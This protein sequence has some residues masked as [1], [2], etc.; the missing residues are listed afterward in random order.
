MQVVERE[1]ERLARREHAEQL[2]DRLVRAMTF[3]GQRE[4]ARQLARRREHPCELL[5]R[6][7]V[8]HGGRQAAHVLVERVDEDPER[9]LALAARRR[10]R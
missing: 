8:E 10:C 1:H 6:E 5:A 7:P 3:V 4:R 9:Q 2:A